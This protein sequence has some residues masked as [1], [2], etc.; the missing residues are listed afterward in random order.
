MVATVVRAEQAGRQRAGPQPTG[1]SGAAGLERPNLEQRR[2]TGGIG[3][4]G[5]RFEFGP[6]LAVVVRAMQ[7]GAEMTVLEHGI[8]R[9]IARIVQRGGD[10]DAREASARDAP[11]AVLA[12]ELQQAFAG[13]D[14]HTLGHGSASGKGLHDVEL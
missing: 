4:E 10:R 2:G 1:L 8:E 5:G 9:A 11:A 13:R 3:R 6:R 14:Q 12:H 7:L